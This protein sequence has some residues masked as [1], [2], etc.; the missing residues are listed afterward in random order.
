M[1]LPPYLSEHE[2][3]ALLRVRVAP[4]SGR[5]EIAG[6]RAGA[7]LVRVNAPPVEGRANT[8]LRKLIAK[9]CRIP[10]ARVELLRGHRGRQKLLRL[11]GLT[12]RDAARRLG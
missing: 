12:A 6:E 2:G 10:A 5:D 7:L 4:R 3:T 9:R 8:A 1:A 11:A